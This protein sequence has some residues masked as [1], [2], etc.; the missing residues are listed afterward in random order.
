MQY[1]NNFL[2]FTNNLYLFS[3]NYNNSPSPISASSL[4]P[5]P[6][7]QTPD[8]VWI[9][10]KVRER[11]VW[12]T[13]QSLH[14]YS[15]DPSEVERIAVKYKRKREQIRV[16]DTDLNILTPQICFRA[17][18]ATGSNMPLLIPEKEIKINEELEASVSQPF[19]ESDSQMGGWYRARFVDDIRGRRTL[20]KT[21]GITAR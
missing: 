9:T 17:A 3:Y 1:F 16:H 5:T 11:G 12:R 6:L 14:V 2:S 21:S 7:A 13:T 10:F 20:F 18:I 19:S 15:S 8:S 4:L